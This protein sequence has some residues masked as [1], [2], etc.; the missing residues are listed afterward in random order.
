MPSHL[1]NTRFAYCAV[2]PAHSLSVIKY[3]EPGSVICEGRHWE[4]QEA[5]SLTPSPKVLEGQ[6]SPSF[7][8]LSQHS[9]SH[10]AET[11]QLGVM[12]WNPSNLPRSSCLYII[13]FLRVPAPPF[14]PGS[15]GS[16]RFCSDTT[17]SASLPVQLLFGLH[18]HLS[19]RLGLGLSVL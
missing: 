3:S 7:L 2:F 12:L 1:C 4:L 14:E 6:P 10:G 9:H 15:P 16:R 13:S 5:G 18:V 11:Q 8:F 17:C 19:G